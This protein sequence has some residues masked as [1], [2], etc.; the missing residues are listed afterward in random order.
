MKIR[1]F[2]FDTFCHVIP[3]AGRDCC[4]GLRPIQDGSGGKSGGIASRG[5][6]TGRAAS[7][8]GLK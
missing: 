4:A 3:G 7:K 5:G 8:V 2:S 1:L 6:T